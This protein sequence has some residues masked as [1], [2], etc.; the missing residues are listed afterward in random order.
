MTSAIDSLYLYQTKELFLRQY[1][2][3]KYLTVLDQLLKLRFLLPSKQ[4]QEKPFL[5]IQFEKSF[6]LR[7]LQWKKIRS[8][9][10][11][12]HVLQKETRLLS[13]MV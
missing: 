8:K 9:D 3:G 1:K 13:A 7:H 5:Q 2:E 6:Y 4:M 12:T 10:E 11:H